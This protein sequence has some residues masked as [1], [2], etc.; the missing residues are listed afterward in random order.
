MQLGEITSEKSD[1]WFLFQYSRKHTWDDLYKMATDLSR[2]MPQKNSYL[3]MLCD[4]R[5]YFS[6][7]CH[8][9]R[10]S[11]TFIGK[12]GELLL[13]W[14]MKQICCQILLN[15]TKMKVGFEIWHISDFTRLIIPL[16]KV[17]HTKHSKHWLYLLASTIDCGCSKR[18]I[19]QTF[20]KTVDVDA[21][22]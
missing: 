5:K 1:S 18:S 8:G 12:K 10:F 16:T 6:P 11:Q 4:F 17:I 2:F 7:L 9:R 21:R 15:S 3:L 13:H 20:W 14:A 19:F 22:R